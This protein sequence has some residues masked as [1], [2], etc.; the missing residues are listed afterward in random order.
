MKIH[1]HV[2]Y[3]LCA[4][5]LAGILCTEVPKRALHPFLLI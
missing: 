2:N 3:I 4:P 5:A 1:A